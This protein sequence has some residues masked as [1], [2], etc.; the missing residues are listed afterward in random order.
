MKYFFGGLLLA[1]LAVSGSEKIPSL[2]EA[3]NQ[4]ELN[5]AA[6]TEQDDAATELGEIFRRVI[7]RNQGDAVFVRKLRAAQEAWM[8]YRDAQLESCWPNED[9]RVYGSIHPTCRSLEL[10]RITHAR[11][12]EL[13]RFLAHDEGEV[14]ACDGSLP[15]KPEFNGSKK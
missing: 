13:A 14:C 11:I 2:A 7:A 9:R 6:A 4:L 8:K 12:A 1:T 10:A 5:Q 15:R 3:K